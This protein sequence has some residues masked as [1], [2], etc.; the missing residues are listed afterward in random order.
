MVFGAGEGGVVGSR[1]GGGGAAVAVGVV[2]DGVEFGEGV[3]V[4]ESVVVG[5]VVDA[6]DGGAGNGVGCGDAA[7]A[8]GGGADRLL[9][10]RVKVSPRSA[11]ASVLRV[12]K[13]WCR[14]AVVVKLTPARPLELPPLRLAG[15]AVRAVAVLVYSR[16][17]M[18]SVL[19][20]SPLRE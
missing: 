13:I 10:V 17:S 18:S 7:A 6:G 9:K 8:A 19:A 2:A 20:A 4:D 11:T 16:I 1:A 12:M 3:D 14:V 15:L 5:I